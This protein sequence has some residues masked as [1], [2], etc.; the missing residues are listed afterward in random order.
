MIIRV[1]VVDDDPRI[2]EGVELLLSTDSRFKFVGSFQTAEA[3]VTEIPKLDPDVVLMDI[4]LGGLGGPS[5]IDCV[6]ELK[7]K[8]P[9][10]QI[11]MLT[12]YEDSDK[13]FNSLIAGATGSAQTRP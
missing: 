12:V 9:Q 8:V 7:R 3:A 6:R 13:V 2:S 11:L 1:C 4:N 5:G 10:I